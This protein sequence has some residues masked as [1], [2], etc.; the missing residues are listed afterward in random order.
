MTTL[1]LLVCL[2][3]DPNLPQIN[4][5]EHQYLI[6]PDGT[7]AFIAYSNWRIQSPTKWQVD[8]VVTKCTHQDAL[9]WMTQGWMK[10]Y[11]LEDFAQLARRWKPTIC[12][13]DLPE[14]DTQPDLCPIDDTQTDPNSQGTLDSSLGQICY[15]V[16][17]KQHLYQDCRYIRD[18]AWTP[19]V[20]DPNSICLTCTAR[21][22]AE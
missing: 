22:L 3:A 2:L 17:G 18:K 1:L 19:C 20:C 11:N 16:G 15:T 7:A 13:P 6:M 4:P 21:R 5:P 8:A 9:W 12:G 14:N 10:L